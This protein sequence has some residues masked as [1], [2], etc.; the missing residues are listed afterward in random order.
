TIGPYEVYTDELF[1]YK[2]AFEA[3]INLRDDQET[4]KLGFFSQHLQSIEDNLPEE[5]QYRVKKLGALSPIR[6]VNEVHPAGDGAHGVMT[7]AYNLPNDD[8]VVA[9]KG[10]KRIMLKNVQQAK[11][12]QI[13]KPIAART[14]SLADQ[15][16]LS[17][18][19]FFTDILAHELCHGL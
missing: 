4:A 18:E 10:S 5:P 3:Y 8:R 17:F 6:L 12:D 15:K 1:N 16:Y 19:W 9:E 2:A 14:L 11:F 7:A 13:L